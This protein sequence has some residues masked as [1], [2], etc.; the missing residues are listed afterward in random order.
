[1]MNLMPYR[2]GRMSR[3]EVVRT[4]P[5]FADFF[6]P[7]FGGDNGTGMKVDVEEKED[8][9]LLEADLPGAARENVKVEVK[10]GVMTISALICEEKEE[11]GKNYI[12]RERRTGTVS[13]AFRVEGIREEE[14]TAQF[15]DGVLRLELPKNQV[16]AEA[17]RRIEIA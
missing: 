8:R 9:Y 11:T 2:Y 3:P 12:C 7:F 5:F 14:I 6:R 15:K 16:P 4:D 1:M 17:V 13:R 10:D